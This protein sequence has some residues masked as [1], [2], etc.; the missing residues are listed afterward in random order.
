MVLYEGI[1]QK[2]LLEFQEEELLQKINTR[3][4]LLLVMVVIIFL[5]GMGMVMMIYS[6]NLKIY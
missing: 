1:N 4:H 5:A 3:K 6:S 2:E